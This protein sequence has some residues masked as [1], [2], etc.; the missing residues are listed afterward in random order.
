MTLLSHYENLPTQYG[1]H[2][3]LKLYQRY[4]QIH[5]SQKNE[6]IVF[7]KNAFTY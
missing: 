5:I 7:F 3:I 1:F 6:E 4:I 2:Y